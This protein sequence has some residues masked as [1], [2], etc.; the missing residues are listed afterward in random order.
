MPIENYF[1]KKAL[2]IG[3]G[4]SGRAAASFLQTSGVKVLGVDRNYLQLENQPEILE[5]KAKGLIIQADCE[6]MDLKTFD[7]IV[8]SPGIPSN[9]P[10]IKKAYEHKKEVIGE[11]ELGCRASCH[12]IIGVTGTNGKT[13]V[14]LLITHILNANGLK[15]KAL[16]NVGAPLTREILTLDFQEIA[17]LEL[18]SYQLDTFQQQVLDE[19]VVLNITP[20]HLERYETMENYAKS[21]FQIGKCLKKSGKLFVENKAAVEYQHLL[22][23][24]HSTYGYLPSCHTYTDLRSVF[25]EGM[26][27]FELPLEWQGK[28]NHDLENLLAAYAICARRGIKPQQFLQALKT[29]QKPSHRVEFVLEKNG[30][31]FYDDSKGTNIDAVMRAVQSI[32][33][34]VFLIAGGVDKGASYVA[35][36]NVFKGHVK[37]VYAIGQAA[38]KIQKELSLHI[39]VQ[40]EANLDDAVKQAYQDA[41]EGDVV[42]LSPGCASFDMFKDYIHR[43]E[44]FKRLVKLL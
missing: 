10:L 43:G 7:L 18:S 8:V 6:T 29:F 40:I 39:K 13:T 22:N 31:H 25:S 1:G 16:G 41:K 33:R 19:A 44:E 37:K 15:A 11:I 4:V 30:I 23:F 17:V 35:W 28:E 12:S 3:L 26:Q 34:P 5:L 2:I 42:L 32:N 36:L 27:Q 14:T 20:D 9:H 21:K 24:P 38:N